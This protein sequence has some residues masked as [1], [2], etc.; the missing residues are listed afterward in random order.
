METD[1]D[2]IHYTLYDRNRTNDVNKQGCQSDEELYNI[3]Y[4]E[5]ISAFLIQAFLERTYILD[6]WIFCLQC[7]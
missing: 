7:W 5:N 4:M 1:K 3:S 6:R 2:H